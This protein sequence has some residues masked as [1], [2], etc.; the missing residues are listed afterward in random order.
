MSTTD[1]APTLTSIKIKAFSQLFIII[2]AL[3][4]LF[5]G[6]SGDIR[7]WGAW[8]FLLV[9]TIYEIIAISFLI[10]NSIELLSQRLT[11]REKSTTQQ[12][13]IVFGGF[14]YLLMYGLPA[15]DHRYGW[16]AVPFWLI[17]VGF[18]I[19]TCGL[20]I[21]FNAL[22]KNCWASRIIQVQPDQKVISTG[23]YGIVRHPFYL[24]GWISSIGTPLALGSYW[25]LI[26]AISWLLMLIIRLLNE[27]KMLKRDLPDYDVYC[28]K[29]KYRLIPGIF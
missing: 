2:V 28:R 11:L 15:I 16:S 23:L 29:V 24:G 26:S 4:F 14:N 10:H 3:F 18:I 21:S 17:I 27:E 25:G 1:N 6:I 20:M 7:Y 13:L 19:L 8:S 5:R 12:L 9:F 22:K